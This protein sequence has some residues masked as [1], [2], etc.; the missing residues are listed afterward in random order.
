M[1]IPALAV[2]SL[3]AAPALAAEEPNTAAGTF[4]SQSITMDVRSAV[5]FRGRSSLDKG[6]AL[7][8]AVSN[9][10]L[11]AEAIANYVDRRR[12][13]DARVKDN[14]SGVV[15]FEFR[16]DGTYR[17]LSY[18]FGPGNGCGY[19]TGEV[20]S[21]VSLANGKFSGKLKDAEADRSFEITLVTPVMADDHGAAL[22]PDGGAPGSAYRA[23]H[24]ALVKADRA[25]LKPLVSSDQQQYWDDSEKRG[26]LGAVLHAMA[27]AHPVKSVQITRGF[28]SGNKA[29]LEIAGET[30]GGKLV[31]EVFLVKEGDGWRVDDEITEHAP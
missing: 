10:R 3:L 12:V 27:N 31:G 25:A 16:P 19:C 8:V 14:E 22:P 5:A 18:S 13:M 7:I 1:R 20:T 17:G 2:L 26:S 23:Y 24:A 11:N 4:K 21:T 28:S 29:V 6:E 15:Y 9:A 30:P